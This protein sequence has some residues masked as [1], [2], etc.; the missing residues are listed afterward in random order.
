[1]DTP[2]TSGVFTMSTAHVDVP[3]FCNSGFLPNERELLPSTQIGLA[4]IHKKNEY[5]HLERETFN[6]LGL[7][8]YTKPYAL[9]SA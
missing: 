3:D 5:G 8:A 1:M 7:Y 6:R 9:R 4:F 2:F